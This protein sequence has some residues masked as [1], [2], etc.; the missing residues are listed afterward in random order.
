[1]LES[2]RPDDEIR[3]NAFYHAYEREDEKKS[4]FSAHLKEYY[5]TAA[6]YYQARLEQK[7]NRHGNWCRC[8]SCCRGRGSHK[9]LE[10]P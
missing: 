8:T 2:D 6:G 1:M 10:Q 4:A 7:T 5:L 3:R 9:R